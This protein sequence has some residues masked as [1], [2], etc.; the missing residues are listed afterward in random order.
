[1]HSY[2]YH[3]DVR[4]TSD[5]GL[6]NSKNDNSD[7]ET[8]DTNFSLRDEDY[9]VLVWG[10][11]RFEVEVYIGLLL[12]LTEFMHVSLLKVTHPA[13]SNGGSSLSVSKGTSVQIGPFSA[14]C[15]V[16]ACFL[17]PNQCIDH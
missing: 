15:S 17:Q 3:I 10:E 8:R 6:L 1:M 16:L 9:S 11:G 13:A 5:P 12:H 14:R 4:R 7:S 2:R